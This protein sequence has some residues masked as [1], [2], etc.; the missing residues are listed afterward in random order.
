MDRLL[1]LIRPL[2][3]EP[4]PT[5]H[6]LVAS[7]E[8]VADTVAE[9]F[10]VEVTRHAVDLG[11]DFTLGRVDRTRQELRFQ[12]AARRGERVST[13]PLS[14]LRRVQFVRA[15]IL[16]VALY[17][18]SASG[19]RAKALHSLRALCSRAL[20]GTRREKKSCL[21]RTVLLNAAA[22]VDPW[23]LGPLQ[24]LKTWARFFAYCSS[25]FGALWAR[26]LRAR[27]HAGCVT[28]HLFTALQRAGF[29]P[30]EDP[31]VWISDRGFAYNPVFDNWV[32]EALASLRNKAWIHMAARRREFS[33][34]YPPASVFRPLRAAFRSGRREEAGLRLLCLAGGSWP[35]TRAARSGVVASATCPHCGADAADACHR[36]WQCPRWQ[37]LRTQLG[38][39]DLAAMAVAQD[40]QPRQLWECGIPDLPLGALAPAPPDA[41]EGLPPQARV[42]FTDGSV[43]R[44]SDLAVAQAGWAYTDGRGNGCFGTLPGYHQT[45]NRAELWSVVSC[46]SAQSRGL[47]ICTD[48]QYVVQG[49][50][51]VAQG[52]L[53]T[54]HRDLWRRFRAL[55]FRPFLLKVLAHLTP[56]QAALRGQPDAICRG[57]AE[58][59]R[60][61]RL[62]ASAPI[63]QPDFLESRAS[64]LELAR[65]IQDA[66]WQLLRAILMVEKR[67][68]GARAGHNR[69]HRWVRRP[70]R[71]RPVL[72][73][74]AHQVVPSGTAFQCLLCRR[75]SKSSRPRDWR[76]RPCLPR[77]RRSPHEA[78]AS[79]LLWHRDG[80]V[81]CHFCGRTSG[82]R[83]KSRLLAQPCQGRGPRALPA[84]PQP[85][86][87]LSAILG[88]A[89]VAAFPVPLG[90][91]QH[92][93]L[94]SEG[95]RCP[96]PRPP[97]PAR[98]FL[99]PPEVSASH[100][101]WED[102]HRVGCLACHRVMRR[103]ERHRLLNSFCKARRLAFRGLAAGPSGPVPLIGEEIEISFGALAPLIS[104]AVPAQSLLE[105]V[106]AVAPEPLGSCSSWSSR[107]DQGGVCA[108]S[109]AC[110]GLCSFPVPLGTCTVSRLSSGDVGVI[111]SGIECAE[112]AGAVARVPLGTCA[113]S[114]SCSLPL[115]SCSAS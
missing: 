24:I 42:M 81:G 101:V 16:A 88:L 70:G 5:K 103:R 57:N 97:R 83:W 63:Y 49:A 46:A 29:T 13:L 26:S 35:P 105:S 96:G 41:V 99:L 86:R 56:E 34:S 87:P 53:P 80:H 92:F 104:S 112:R 6:Q 7:S 106:V 33:G 21:A 89:P 43:F 77:T 19:L 32:P 85:L 22:C 20:L 114:S 54:T 58:A 108:S 12:E 14:R 82:H 39:L 36:F 11:T 67:P 76:Y 84:F 100:L 51:D 4:N 110:T 90:T 17:G 69:F 71:S 28:D 59:D 37:G 8:A 98:A 40:F 48:S 30:G 23:V 27:G 47:C 62:G 79:H 91:D 18:A 55:P 72:S 64:L 94:M 113:A 61:A 10:G 25:T 15:E 38:V 44:S 74:G 65:R 115:G 60:L 2:G 102:A 52:Q 107:A 50:G 31:R 75:L 1:Q 95:D 73:Y 78:S 93:E 66:Q 68:F 111:P 3:L 109:G 9:H 45:I